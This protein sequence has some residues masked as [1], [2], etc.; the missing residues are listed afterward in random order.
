VIKLSVSHWR[1]ML[2]VNVTLSEGMIFL[3]IVVFGIL[4][5]VDILC[6]QMNGNDDMKIIHWAT[7][8]C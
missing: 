1:S 5:F 2:M 4:Q 6:C 3:A 8:C 7:F